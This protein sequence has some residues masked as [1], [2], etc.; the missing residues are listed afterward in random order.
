MY[1]QSYHIHNVLNEYRKRLSQSPGAKDPRQ[2]AKPTVKDSVQLS[3]DGQRQ[4]IINQVSKDIVKQ[5]TQFGT[6]RKFDET[7]ASYQRNSDD[8][9]PEKKH[10]HES[11]F[12]YTAIDENN[13]KWTHTLPIRKI[14]SALGTP[15]GKGESGT[16]GLTGPEESQS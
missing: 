11:E 14:D 8:K 13:R 3:N 16:Q 10:G 2:A 9:R 6:Q 5:I 15:I 1:I 4:A 12:V 7:L